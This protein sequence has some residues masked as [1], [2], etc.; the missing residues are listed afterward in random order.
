MS[1]SQSVLRLADA[2]LTHL[3]T[4]L[5][6]VAP[7]TPVKTS[8]TALIP[9]ATATD[10]LAEKAKALLQTAPR[11]VLKAIGR[12]FAETPVMAVDPAAKPDAAP[13][14]EDPS[15]KAP[16]AVTKSGDPSGLPPERIAPVLVAALKKILDA[17]APGK[18]LIFSKNGLPVFVSP[19]ELPEQIHPKNGPKIPAQLLA[20]LIAQM[21]N[22]VE[23]LAEQA[24]ILIGAFGADLIIVDTDGGFAVANFKGLPKNVDPISFFL[25]KIVP[26]IAKGG[27]SPE[28]SA[29]EEEGP[30]PKANAFNG[31][32][33]REYTSQEIRSS[34]DGLFL[35]DETMNRLWK[36]V[37]LRDIITH[38]KD[39]ILEMAQ[40]GLIKLPN[41]GILNGPPGVGKSAAME[42][43]ANAMF[44]AGCYV[45]TLSLAQMEERY[46]GSFANNLVQ[47]FEHASQEAKKRGKPSLIVIDEATNLVTGVANSESAARYYQGALDA[48]K[49]YATGHPE[50]IFVLATNAPNR[51]LDGPLSRSMRLDLVSFGLPDDTLRG[52][53]FDYYLRTSNVIEGL[54]EDQLRKLALALPESMGA[55]IRKFCEDYYDRIIAREYAKQGLTTEL[56]ITR[57]IE[58][59]GKEI[60]RAD[61]KSQVSFESLLAELK[62]FAAALNETKV[63]PRKVGFQ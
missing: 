28:A 24:K 57:Y 4:T 59:G 26:Q 22:D 42:A 3:A 10:A 30:S 23:A 16:T 49:A 18:F 27:E 40:K 58:E 37:G 35:K 17:T 54:T 15:A 51:D 20:K 14:S 21:P 36:A 63:G 7:A 60:T 13:T 11:Q 55:D 46:V 31:G 56:D 62:G 5:H 61:V 8:S 45:H 19:E 38:R 41:G 9:S 25:E 43:T 32:E 6:A 44:R 1:F 12:R 50:L 48:L 53:M 39:N 33:V 47:Q 34:F 52:K 29:N 2:G